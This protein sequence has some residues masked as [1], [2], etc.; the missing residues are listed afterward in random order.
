[1]AFPTYGK[2]LLK[3]FTESPESPVVRTEMEDGYAKESLVRSKVLVPRSVTYLYTLSEYQSFKA[4]FL[5]EAKG[6]LF[7]DW[8]NPVGGVVTSVRMLRSVYSAKA[9]NQGEGKE[10][11]VEVSFILESWEF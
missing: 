9:V 1:M 10:L 4:W 11:G 5:A 8:I 7:F 3:G 2:H 6:G